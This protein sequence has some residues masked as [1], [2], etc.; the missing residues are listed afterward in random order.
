MT[1]SNDDLYLDAS[2][3]CELLGISVSTLYAYVSRKRVRSEPIEGS[4]S[5]RYWRADIERL[6]GKSP[7][8]VVAQPQ[9]PLVASSRITLITDGRLYFRGHDA[10]ELSRTRSLESI[11]SLLWQTDEATT[12]GEPPADASRIWQQLRPSL[13]ELSVQERTIAM[14]PMIE[15]ADPRAYDLT[16]A[17]FARTGADVVRWYATL[18][19]QAPRPDTQPLHRF[20]AQA[21]KAPEGFDEVI[22][23]LLVLAADHEFDPITY[24]VRAVAN[25]GVTP[26]QA[27]TTGLIAAQGQRFQAERYGATMRFLDEILAGAN[28]QAAVVRR[29]RA[30]EM[31]PGWGDGARGATPDPRAA[32]VLQSLERVL[33]GDAE[34]KRLKDADRVAFDATGC[35]MSFIVPALFVGRRLGLDGNELALS[36]L[37]RTAGWIAHAMEQFHDNALVRP[38][39]SYTG[40][41]PA[42]GAAR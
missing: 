9:I 25:V 41:L 13:R 31:L 10:I 35:T 7:E 28:G 1:T 3:A 6:A 36:A 33:R 19:V 37:G 2:S 29:L 34:L 22:R 14:F 16:P 23:Q 11:A 17:G 32:A 5:R 40:T 21:L 39:A 15:R 4:R 26:Y 24:A 8:V 30:G 42:G 27:V 18:M 38:R 12:F 20:V